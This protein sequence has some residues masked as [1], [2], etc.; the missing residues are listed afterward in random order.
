MREREKKDSIEK[1]K[2]N[3]SIFSLHRKPGSFYKEGIQNFVEL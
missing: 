1:I 2:N 3:T